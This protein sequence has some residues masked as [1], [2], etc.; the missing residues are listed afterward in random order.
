MTT[1]LSKDVYIDPKFQEEP[2][3][4]EALLKMRNNSRG[5]VLQ[6]AFVGDR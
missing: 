2:K 4:A 6:R 5:D 3:V 1:F